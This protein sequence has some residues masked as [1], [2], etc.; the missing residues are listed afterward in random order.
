[1][2]ALGLHVSAREFQV[3]VKYRLQIAVY[4]QKKK[5]HY[6]RS[7][8]LGVFGDNALSCHGRGDAISWHDRIRDRI[9]SACSAAYSSPVIE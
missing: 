1:M 6:Y 5:C 3:T 8:T 7:V 2:P 9:A 4:D